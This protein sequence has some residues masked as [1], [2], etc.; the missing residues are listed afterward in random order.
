MRLAYLQADPYVLRLQ[1]IRLLV[2]VGHRR[3]I[4]DGAPCWWSDW[5][6]LPALRERGVEIFLGTDNIRDAWSPM[7]MIGMV[8]RMA[9]HAYRLG[10][11]RDEDLLA[12]LDL[13][14]SAPHRVM[15]CPE[16]LSEGAP[17]DFI[18]VDAER[19]CRT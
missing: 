7:T 1:R 14:T 9:L 2:S 13:A 4:G 18:V 17:A 16:P 11:R 15:G 3:A 6:P 10:L 19:M 8:D 12:L 5:S